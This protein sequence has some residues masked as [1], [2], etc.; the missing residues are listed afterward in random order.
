MR[1][2]LSA[3]L[4]YSRADRVANLARIGFVAAEVARHGGIAICAAIAP[5]AAVRRRMRESI[6]AAG[7]GFVEVHVST[8]L[9]TCEARDPKGLYASVRA[10]LMQGLT[11]VDGAWEPPERSELAV[12]TT[13][14]DPDAATLRVMAALER[15]RLVE[16]PAPCPVAGTSGASAGRRYDYV[17]VVGPGRSGSTFLWQLLTAHPA[18][19]GPRIKEGYYYRS[20]RRYR[21][22]RRG[23]GGALLLD[24]ANTAW[25]D[26]GLDRLPAPR[27]RVLL[28]VLLRRHRDRAVSVMAYRKSRALPDAWAGGQVLERHALGESLTA[29]ALERLFGIGADLLAVGFETLTGEPQLVLDTLSRLC[30]VPPVL[31]PT[32]VPANAAERARHPLLV[33]AGKLAALALRF[34][35][36]HRLLQALKDSP[37]VR[38][39]FFRPLEHRPRL[40]AGAEA[41][42]DRQYRDCVAALDA[43]GERPGAGLWFVGA[44]TAH[45]RHHED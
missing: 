31:A 1:E 29:A 17:L 10:G 6:G 40:S 43:A 36:A 33:G 27:R 2:T 7:G 34:A 25:A 16:T 23:L 8:P 24:V 30:G 13:G 44:C 14:I 35:G 15:L 3:G 18:F 39:L 45:G 11:G 28:V 22:A 41:L 42:L 20:A 37:R 5:Y 26:A 32:P 9:A 21:R 19:A 12:D 4:G 38:G